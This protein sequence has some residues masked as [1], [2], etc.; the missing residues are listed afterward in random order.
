MHQEGTKYV[1]VYNYN[2]ELR[3]VPLGNVF[4]EDPDDW[5]LPDK[6]FTIEK[7]LE[8][9]TLDSDTGQLTMKSG[10]PPITHEITC[11]VSDSRHQSSTQAF[12]YVEVNYIGDEAILSAGSIVLSGKCSEMLT[13]L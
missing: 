1:V 3:N 11:I 4:V 9:F 5:D 7:G 12:V 10:A 13:K 2:G 6:T 8:W